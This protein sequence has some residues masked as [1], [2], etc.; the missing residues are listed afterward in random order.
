MGLAEVSSTLWRERELL[1]LL[2]FKLEE[3]QLLLASGRSRWLARATREVEVVLEEIRRCE[4]LRAVQVDEVAAELGLG[5]GP[6]LRALADAAGEPWGSLLHEHRKA[7]LAATTEIQTMA[8]AN[9]D[10]LASGQRAARDALLSMTDTDRSETYTPRGTPV[11][12][13]AGAR[14]VDE[15]I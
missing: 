2:L 9:R 15:A 5:A 12:A 8:E 3:E 6:S 13:G 11:A 10:L 1:E 14:L 4:L 7:F